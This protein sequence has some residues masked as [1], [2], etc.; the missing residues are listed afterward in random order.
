MF[1]GLGFY[2]LNILWV[3]CLNK[4]NIF[5]NEMFKVKLKYS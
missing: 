5:K 1:S 2:M 4:K 3:Y